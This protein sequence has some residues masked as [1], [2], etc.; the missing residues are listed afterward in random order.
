MLRVLLYDQSGNAVVEAGDNLVANLPFSVSD[1]QGI[2]IDKIIL[3]DVNNNKIGIINIEIYYENA[4]EIPIDYSLSQ[5]Y[6]NPF[7]PSTSVKF[8]VPK[9][10]IVSIKV[11]DMLGQEVATL[12]SGNAERGSYTLVWNGK[13]KNNNFISSGSYIYRMTANDGAFTVSKKMIFLK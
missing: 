4:P 9:A 12:F 7:N 13:D 10:G 6:P 8:T 1:P 11:F 2:S 5:N 3:V